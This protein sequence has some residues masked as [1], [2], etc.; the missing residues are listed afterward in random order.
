MT[1]E[2][3]AMRKRK[4]RKVAVQLVIGGLVGMGAAKLAPA[5][6]ESG[7]LGPIGP[8]QGA[9]LAVALF[10][11]VIG[12]IIGL[13]VVNVRLGAQALNVEDEE[14]LREQRR[15]L[16][17]SALSMVLMAALLALLALAGPG[18]LV[19]P[20]LALAVTVP[21]VA[22]L[23]LL[24]LRM[25]RVM[26]ELMRAVTRE[27]GEIAYYLVLAV[28]GGWALLAHLKFV[29]DMAMLDFVTLNYVLLLVASVIANGRHG[30]MRVR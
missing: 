27:C 14:D 1:H 9:A 8:S 2:A 21:A 19:S 16:A 15:V 25:L 20:A 4:V 11:G 26:D 28:A 23:I 22:L 5:L 30:L 10:Y 3:E 7:V 12:I 24:S 17:L 13:G 29:P 6:L 18:R